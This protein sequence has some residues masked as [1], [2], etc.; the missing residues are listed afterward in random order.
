M[1]SVTITMNK[2][3]YYLLYNLTAFER[4]SL[5]Q[6]VRTALYRMAGEE[7]PPYKR[8]WSRR[9]IPPLFDD[10]PEHKPLKA[11]VYLTEDALKLADR[12]AKEKGMSRR[13]VVSMALWDYVYQL[14]REKYARELEG[15]L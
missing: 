12:L 13:G 3:Q 9:L 15:F 6:I 5:S 14:A 4:Q 7:P 10:R 2:K 8:T 1:A 11:A